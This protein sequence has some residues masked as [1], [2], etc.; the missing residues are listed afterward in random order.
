MRVHWKALGQELYRRG[1]YRKHVKW[2]EFKIIWTKRILVLQISYIFTRLAE[3][4]Y[5]SGSLKLFFF[6]KCGLF[7][8]FFFFHVELLT[9]VLS[10]DD[11]SVCHWARIIHNQIQSW[12]GKQGQSSENDPVTI[13]ES[14]L[15][16]GRSAL[17]TKLIQHGV[18]AIDTDNGFIQSL[19]RQTQLY[20]RSG[21][22]DHVSSG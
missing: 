9:G 8:S 3:C 22:F 6:N 1:N 20:S 11:Q 13:C 10:T 12:G 4:F 5:S 17:H 14:V 18:A 19:N 2:I 15:L 7:F 16:I 21:Q